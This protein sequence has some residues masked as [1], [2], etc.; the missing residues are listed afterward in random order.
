MQEHALQKLRAHIAVPFLS[1]ELAIPE[2]LIQ[3]EMLTGVIEGH[4]MK[5]PDRMYVGLVAVLYIAAFSVG[6]IVTFVPEHVRSSRDPDP[7]T[8]FE[9]FIPIAWQLSTM[10]AG[11]TF[12]TGCISA[13]RTGDFKHPKAVYYA[14]WASMILFCF[15]IFDLLTLAIL[16]IQ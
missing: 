3:N 11:V 5:L 1:F 15:F 8:F 16:P 10:G 12:I 6:L 9:V 7:Q 13:F 2:R 14:R 4:E